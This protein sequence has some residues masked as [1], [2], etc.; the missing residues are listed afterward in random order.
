MEHGASLIVPQS[1]AE[2]SF[3]EYPSK[4]RHIPVSEQNPAPLQSSSLVHEGEGDLVVVEV[5]LVEVGC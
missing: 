4:Q 3:C 5:V 2:Q 1:K